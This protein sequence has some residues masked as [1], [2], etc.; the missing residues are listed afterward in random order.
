MICGRMTAEGFIPSP[1]IRTQ[2]RIMKLAEMFPTE[3]NLLEILQEAF[4][5]E[6]YDEDCLRDLLNLLVDSMQCD[7]TFID[8]VAETFCQSRDPGYIFS[9]QTTR[10]LVRIHS[11]AS[12]AAGAQRWLN[13][14]AEGTSSGTVPPDV[15]S[16]TTLLRDLGAQ[17]PEASAAYHWVLQRMQ[18]DG[19]A[20]DLP[21][22]NALL[23]SEISRGHYDKAF[24]IYQLLMK[25]RTRSVTPDAYTYAS[26]FRAQHRISQPHS[27]HTRRHRRPQGAPSPRQLYQEMLDCH[28][29]RTRGRLS[30]SSPVV[31]TTVLNKALRVF[32]R[33]HDYAAVY[34]VLRTFWMCKLS[35]TL[36]TYRVVVGGL[37]A[38]IQ[39]ELRRLSEAHDPSVHWRGVSW[40]WDRVLPGRP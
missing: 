23:A 30:Q 7:P 40:D 4:S 32:M 15:Q 29:S 17:D 37:L 31:D 2:M 27:V 24:A 38:R 1:S 22:F 28:D 12:S 14:K 13:P 34:V 26:L 5:Q 25:H 19:L 8:K 18:E 11:Q 3:E 39:N 35:P 33:R 16:Y 10:L 6:S 21:F 36:A 20:P 9:P